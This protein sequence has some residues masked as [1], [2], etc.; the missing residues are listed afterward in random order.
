MAAK[1]P[2]GEEADTCPDGPRPTLRVRG[3]VIFILLLA[4]ILLGTR[5]ADLGSPYPVSYLALHAL[6]AFALVGFT[7]TTVRSSY[8]LP[9]SAVRGAALLTFLTTLGATLGGLAFLYGGGS[10]ASLDVMESLGAIALIGAILLVVLG[11]A[12]KSPSPAPA[13]SPPP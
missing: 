2:P 10:Q 5:L 6:L 7:A 12:P 11:G 9:S 8:C 1:P 3:V 13:G 4:A